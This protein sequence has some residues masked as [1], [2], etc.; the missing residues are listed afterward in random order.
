M[1][2]QVKLGAKT[3][4]LQK[5]FLDHIDVDQV[6][7]RMAYVFLIHYTIFDIAHFLQIPQVFLKLIKIRIKKIQKPLSDFFNCKNNIPGYLL[8]VKSSI[9]FENNVIIIRLT[10]ER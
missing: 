1:L 4:N 6:I 5:L 2:I 7:Y 3:T 10:V 8:L 9:S